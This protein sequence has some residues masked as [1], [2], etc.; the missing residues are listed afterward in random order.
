MEGSIGK[1]PETRLKESASNKSTAEDSKWHSIVSPISKDH[2]FFMLYLRFVFRKV[3][4]KIR[5]NRKRCRRSRFY[6]LYFFLSSKRGF[7]EDELGRA[8]MGFTSF[9]IFPTSSAAL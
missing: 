1:P 5:Y 2:I 6:F 7:E 3:K 8:L 4:V 9:N